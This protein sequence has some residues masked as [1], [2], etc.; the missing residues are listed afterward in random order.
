MNHTENWPQ[1]IS[2]LEEAKIIDI[3]LYFSGDFWMISHPK[4][5]YRLRE[6]L[7]FSD[8]VPGFFIF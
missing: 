5:T 4:L 8:C 1:H 2:D 3:K 6:Y 7:L